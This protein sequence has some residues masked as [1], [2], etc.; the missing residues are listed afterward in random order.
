MSIS[1]N[2]INCGDDFTPAAANGEVNGEAISLDNDGQFDGKNSESIANHQQFKEFREK[3]AKMEMELK[4]AKLEIENKEQ[5]LKH[6]EFMVEQMKLKEKWAKIEQEKKKIAVE[7][8]FTKMQNVQRILLEK[9]SELEKQQ[10]EQQSKTNSD[11]LSK[12]QNDQKILEKVSELAKEQ[13]QK[14][15]AFL[16]FRQNYWNANVCDEN[17]K[18]T[19]AKS[20][21]VHYKGDYKGWRSVFAK[22]PI[23]PDNNLS[24]IFY[25]E[26]SIGKMNDYLISFGFAHKQQTEE[27]YKSVRHKN[28]TYV[29]ENNGEIWI[30]G[31]G[32]GTNAKYSYGVGDT[33]GIGVHLITR[34]IILTK[35][36]LCLDFSN[37]FVAPCFADDSFYYP[38]VTLATFDDK[39]EANFGPNFKFDLS[40]LLMKKK[41]SPFVDQFVSF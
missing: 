27:S 33:V 13:K 18:I 39:I 14:R 34:Q 3:F 21:I 7:E 23:L 37:L 36:G 8:Q 25:Y 2:S 32:K 11:Q 10:K 35:N 31:E 38:F 41:N 26:I 28:G 20:L 22:H 6:Q 9:I 1:T 30:N 4:M 15:K 17:L 12:M 5:K 16:Y 24:N 19:G 40:T 29:Y